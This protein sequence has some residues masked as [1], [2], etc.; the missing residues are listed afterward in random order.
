MALRP[1]ILDDFGIVSALNWFTREFQKVYPHM[2]GK[3]EINLEER[4]VPNAIKTPIFR[5]CQ[6]AFNN[7]ARHSKA[8]MIRLSLTMRGS[9][10]TLEVQD[11]G[12]GIGHD[13]LNRKK[14]RGRGL[15]LLSMEERASLSGGV[16]T[17]HSERRR[18]TTVKVS[19]SLNPLLPLEL[20]GVKVRNP[21]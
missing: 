5:I 20:L 15:G 17:I 8:K 1:S 4:Q 16:F 10:L 7:T 2:E 6:E 18:G 19:W 3:K 14:D 11:N 13:V 9:F 21:R 12:A